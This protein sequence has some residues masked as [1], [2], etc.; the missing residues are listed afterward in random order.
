MTRFRGPLLQLLRRLCLR[1]V[2]YCLR[3]V[4]GAV[5]YWLYKYGVSINYNLSWMFKNLALVFL[6]FAIPLLISVAYFTLAERK[7]LAAF[8]D[9][10]SA[11]KFTSF[12]P[13]KALIPLLLAVVGIS[14]H[15]TIRSF[16][17]DNPITWKKIYFNQKKGLL[18]VQLLG[19]FV[20]VVIIAGLLF[21]LACFVLNTPIFLQIQFL[22]KFILG[23]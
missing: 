20:T 4:F 11:L 12:H 10:N 15:L 18:F 19:V 1:L 13:N 17:L 9:S 23:L 22:T 3:T 14:F 21:G 8:K 16:I 5:V 2:V 7:V 6:G